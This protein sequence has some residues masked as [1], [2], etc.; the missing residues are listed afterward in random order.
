MVRDLT[1]VVEHRK[2]QPGVGATEPGRPYNA[3]YPAPAAIHRVGRGRSGYRPYDFAVGHTL[4]L[5]RG[6]ERIDPREQAKQ[7]RTRTGQGR[8]QAGAEPEPV[9]R[10]RLEP[11]DQLHT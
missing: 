2:V 7:A 10:D 1:A 9:V 5:F 4:Q 6:D 3:A 8:V 11:T